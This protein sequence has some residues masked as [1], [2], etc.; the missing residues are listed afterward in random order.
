MKTAL[1]FAWL[2]VASTACAGM[3]LR[4]A[5]ELMLGDAGRVHLEVERE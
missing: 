3:L 1:A 5:D 4:N 2:R